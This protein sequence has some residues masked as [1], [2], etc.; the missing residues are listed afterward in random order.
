M[1][2]VAT[3]SAAS[4]ASVLF[5]T[6]RLVAVH[7]TLWGTAIRSAAGWARGVRRRREM[8]AYTHFRLVTLSGDERLPTPEESLA[9]LRWLRA[10]QRSAITTSRSFR[11]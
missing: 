4:N 5:A 2:E 9:Y 8:R 7:P 10:T 6:A 3:H 1:N 11:R